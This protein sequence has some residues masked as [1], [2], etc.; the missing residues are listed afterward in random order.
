[1]SAPPL[2]SAA[3]TWPGRDAERVFVRAHRVHSANALP[4]VWWSLTTPARY[5]SDLNHSARASSSRR[6]AAFAAQGWYWL[7]AR[8]YAIKI[9]VS[10]SGSALVKDRDNDFRRESSVS[11]AQRKARHAFARAGRF[12]NGVRVSRRPASE[13]PRISWRTASALAPGAPSLSRLSLAQR[14]VIFAYRCRQ[15]A[16]SYTT[17]TR[18]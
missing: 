15:T 18:I 8:E 2:M 6:V 14:S 5:G 17:K 9:S 12:Q 1:M 10:A 7:A 11:A 3:K 4:V 16:P 13:C